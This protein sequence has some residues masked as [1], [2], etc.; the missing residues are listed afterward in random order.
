MKIN[1]ALEIDTKAFS[2][3]CEREMKKRSLEKLKE[4]SVAAGLSENAIRMVIV[5]GR[6]SNKTA[7]KLQTVGIQKKEYELNKQITLDDLQPEKKKEIIEI[8]NSGEN[9]IIDLNGTKVIADKYTS[10]TLTL[11]DGTILHFKGGK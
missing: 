8:K 5:R 6:M 11:L 3:C 2:R 4:L 10:V 1:Q 9:L 7:E